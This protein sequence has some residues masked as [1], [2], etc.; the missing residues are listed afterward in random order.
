VEKHHKLWINGSSEDVCS[1]A[2]PQVDGIAVDDLWIT[3]G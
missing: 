3:S 1:Y 2:C